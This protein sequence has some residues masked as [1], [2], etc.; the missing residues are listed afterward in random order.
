LL[1]LRGAATQ[2]KKGK[3]EPPSTAVAV[4]QLE[5]APFVSARRAIDVSG[6]GTNNSGRD[7]A[8]ARDLALAKGITINGLVILSPAP[9]DWNPEHT[10]PPGG[11]VEYYK[12][13]VVGGPGAFVMVA[14]DFESFGQVMINKLIGE[15][16][17]ASPKRQI[18]RR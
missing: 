4:Q 8:S 17:L 7:L 2:F 3:P 1:G 11:L 18:A 5:R 16:S 14:Q 15:I 9:L 12:H 13:N 6:D 10:N